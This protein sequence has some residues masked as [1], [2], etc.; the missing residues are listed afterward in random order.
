[1]T[2]RTAVPASLLISMACLATA[3]ASSSPKA[4]EATPSAQ[5]EAESIAAT[6]GV[7][8]SAPRRLGDRIR[9]FGVAGQETDIDRLLDDVAGADAVFLGETHNDDV[10]H[11]VEY[12]VLQGLIE[13]TGGKMILS[14]EMFERDAQA[15]LN[16][17]LANEIDETTFLANTRPWGNYQTAYRPLIELAKAEG[18][19]VIAANFPAP[20]RRKIRGQ[21]E[22]WE[23]LTSEDR[24]WSPR[25]LFPNSVAYW[26]RADRATRGHM[27]GGGGTRTPEERLFDGQSLWDNAMGEA[28][29]D[30]ITAHPGHLV[31]HVVGGFH[32]Q[33]RDG[34]VAQTARRAPKADLRVINVWP[35]L[36]LAEADG[37]G[38]ESALG[39][40]V[41]L[42]AARAADQNEGRWSVQVGGDLQY[43][44]RV[45]ATA[46]DAA[47]APLLIWLGDDGARDDDGLRYWRVALG[48]SAAIVAID[49]LHLSEEA[50]LQLGGRWYWTDSFTSDASRIQ[51]GLERLLDYVT[52]RFP[53]D[54][55][56]VVIAGRGTGATAILW[57]AMYTGRLN[58]TLIAADP[59][60]TGRL[61][62]AGLPAEKS[63]ISALRVIAGED[64]RDAMNKILE[65]YVDLDLDA[66]LLT[67][68]SAPSGL[69]SAVETAVRSGLGLSVPTPAA[70]SASTS[71]TITLANQTPTARRWAEL[72]VRANEARGTATELVVA[73]TAAAAPIK[74]LDFGGVFRVADLQIPGALPTAPGPFGGTTVLVVPA[75]TDAVGRRAWEAL[76]ENDPLA[77]RSRFLRIVLAFEDAS[78]SLPE[79]LTTLVAAGRKNVLIVPA[80]FCA[81]GDQMRALRETAGEALD[82]MTVHWLPGL[83]G[84]LAT[85]K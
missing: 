3:C 6:E 80:Q 34:T 68:A 31:L 52:R 63:S 33:Y 28:V 29:A 15:D 51:R 49:P 25:E 30:A 32:V 43:K 61:Q 64:R 46:T 76:V 12:E 55:E 8:H 27:G 14:L 24:V 58:A 50:D 54:G 38:G 39:D 20:L 10:T 42:T 78:P 11:Q 37:V 45:P 77:K 81:T 66:T 41:V 44:I 40:Y 75:G 60:K 82:G 16:A 59:R 21:R 26:E 18:V 1:M 36:D 7:S 2:S 72:Y 56:R 48:E 73:S 79:T 85:L 17:Y 65:E 23:A 67:V 9:V 84:R 35:Q 22:Q 70:A 69:L 5:P 57:T 47:P 13:R 71:K 62:M 83:G 4:V 53:V 74:A 19:P